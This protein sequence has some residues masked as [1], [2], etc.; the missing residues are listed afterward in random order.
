MKYDVNLLC[1]EEEQTRENKG[2]CCLDIY[3]YRK[4][5]REGVEHYREIRFAESL[6]GNW[7]PCM[8]RVY[9]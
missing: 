6:K 9:S 3:I 4:N 5:E 2:E 8:Y 1:W 7:V